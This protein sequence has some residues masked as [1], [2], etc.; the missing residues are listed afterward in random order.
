MRRDEGDEVDEVDEPFSRTATTTAIIAAS[1]SAMA[2]TS[3]RFR[4]CAWTGE[5]SV[6]RTTPPAAMSAT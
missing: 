6:S 4:V 3:T 2:D 1:A 5:G